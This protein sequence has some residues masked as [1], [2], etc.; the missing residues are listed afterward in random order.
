MISILFLIINLL[1]NHHS[2]KKNHLS[3]ENMKII[4]HLLA[5]FIIPNTNI[6]FV[7]N[8]YNLKFAYRV[9]VKY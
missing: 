1:K 6:K 3:L 9:I 5:N 8:D 4:N 2:G 7:M